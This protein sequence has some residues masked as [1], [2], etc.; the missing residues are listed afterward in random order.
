MTQAAPGQPAP[1]IVLTVILKQRAHLQR[2]I[3]YSLVIGTLLLL[4]P[5]W[6]MFE[7]YGRV[8]NS[9]NT[10]TLLWLLVMVMGVYVVVEVLDLVRSRALHAVAEAFNKVLKEPVFDAVF[11]ANLKKQPGGTTQPFNDLKALRDFIASPFVTAVL[12]TP[13]AVICLVL[14][15][16]LGFWL[17]VLA[18]IGA[19]VQVWLIWLTQR[20]TMPLLTNASVASIAAQNYASNALR[21]A[22]V[23]ESMG[24][25]G[26][27]HAQWV[28]RQNKFLARQAEA[29][30]Y[31]GITSAVAKMLQVMQGSVL[32]GGATWAM[33]HNN[34]WGGGG[35]VIVASILGGRALQPL[36]QLV[37]Q[38]RTFVQ[39]RDAQQR[40]NNL[41]ANFAP[42]EPSMPL[43][44]PEGK[45]VVEDVQA[46]APGSPLR[47]LH[48]VKFTAMPG[49]LTLIIGP[50]ASG[51]ST[52]ARLLVGVWPCAAGKVRL[53][54]ADVY[55]WDKQQ[56]G[57]HMGYLPQNVELFDGT[58][59]ENVARF[60][61]VDMDA[62][63]A[64]IEI[65]GMRSTI[66]ALP[67]GYETRIGDDGAVLSGG[68]RQRLGLAR[69]LYGT[70]KVLVL[71]EPN[72]SLDAAGDKN[73][74]ELI[75]RLKTAGMTIVAITHRNTLMPAVDKIVLLHDGKVLA[76][77]PRD[78]VLGALAKANE[79]RAA[80]AAKP[81]A[82][83]AA[84]A[85]PSLTVM[86]MAQ[87]GAKA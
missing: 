12:D 1:G 36:A 50:T 3:W 63:K 30:D 79:M 78:E 75:T 53:D 31:A 41:L 80:A 51:K 11:Q 70:P 4:V 56:L 27:V 87:P 85:G 32:L 17:G 65:T 13:A 48:G 45:L 20:R 33:L 44:A 72:S 5:S 46:G 62:V 29:S 37:A 83:V 54:G 10:T 69:A 19:A 26:R 35:M 71:D 42:P 77:G 9:R 67:D 52:L 8:L 14:L 6:Y 74:L 61:D 59:A 68:Q 22:Q 16:A 28:K 24:M 81:A 21:N 64:A 60:G 47:I 2:A 23:I 66:E 57:P 18:L 49:E 25:L 15:F 73:L 86:P 39:A 43:P 34:L 40:M 58:V 38:W 7:V 55:A 82:P 84:P 76:F